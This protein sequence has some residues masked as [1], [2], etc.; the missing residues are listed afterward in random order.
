M[1]RFRAPAVAVAILLSSLLMAAC[2]TTGPAGTPPPGGPPT[3]GP[4]GGGP[5][6][7]GPTGLIS[8]ID[9]AAA[10]PGER[11][12]VTG[13]GFGTTGAATV[14]D[15]AAEIVSWSA[16]TI[17][18]VVP[19][20]Q[21][22]WQ[23]LAVAPEG[24]GSGTAALFVGAETTPEAA[25]DA[26][27]FQEFLDALAPGT[28]VLL[29]AGE[30]GLAGHELIIDGVHLHGHPDGTSIELGSGGMVVIVSQGGA[31]GVSDLDVDGA[32]FELRS[33]D[34]G[35][36]VTLQA[37]PTD[38]TLE[39]LEF[40]G[41]QFGIPPAATPIRH[42]N[43]KVLESHVVASSHVWLQVFSSLEIDGTELLGNE[44]YLLSHVGSTTISGSTIISQGFTSIAADS[45]VRISDSNVRATDGNLSVTAYGSFA[46]T[47]PVPG[48][49]LIERSVLEA[50]EVAANGTPDS[51]SGELSIGAFGG[52]VELLGNPRIEAVDEVHI[53]A[54]AYGGNAATVRLVDNQL[55]G[56]GLDSEGTPLDLPW[57]M[58]AEVHV[59]LN[60]GENSV[61]N[62]LEVTGNDLRSGQRLRVLAGTHNAN[63]TVTGNRMVAG[64]GGLL[65]QMEIS[66]VTGGRL[67]VT[68]NDLEA[69][70]I[71]R[72]R[73]LDE[74]GA[75]GEAVF[76]RNNVKVL[77]GYD[78]I[79]ALS[80]N[81]VSCAYTDNVLYVGERSEME[82]SIY[83][84]CLRPDEPSSTGYEVSRNSVEI[85]GS[86]GSV[87][88]YADAGVSISGNEFDAVELSVENGTGTLQVVD[89]VFSRAMIAL[90]GLEDSVVFDDN[91]V[92]SLANSGTALLIRGGPDVT[93]AG[94]TFERVGTFTGPMTGV[95]FISTLP[96]STV[97]LAGNTFRAYT[98]A[99]RFAYESTDATALVTGNNFDF[100]LDATAAVA[101]V[102]LV[103]SN[104]TLD[105]DTNR[106]GN[107][108]TISQLDDGI[109]LSTYGTSSLEVIFG[110]ILSN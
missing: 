88:V 37:A 56:A 83:L 104:L 30:L 85:A 103:D 36:I 19:E 67:L 52:K 62:V 75:S 2:Q 32:Y 6:I 27:R 93:V 108:T 96:G 51:E 76:S 87:S 101:Q 69:A 44:V 28:H 65:G 77:G 31:A 57:N 40:S 106:W 58:P 89:N 18:L 17:E 70:D 110:T 25:A 81:S 86:S 100:V 7:D 34:P 29:P 42:A 54:T 92:E 66:G 78:S 22:G 94:N 21:G 82:P 53:S 11:V 35:G 64:N 109:R 60:G 12:T 91:E 38:V 84:D 10:L 14:G 26:Q 102:S 63:A 71:V 4:P 61:M 45:S 68:D 16:D 47:P 1:S 8:A 24:G 49:V 33:A 73:S 41:A 13:E 72:V 15:A 95:G 98:H 43:L 46:S 50:N 79:L 20:A 105:L 97:T 48:E 80:L 39:R 9:P 107:L 5:P 90:N 3:D 55:I 23:T 74:Q 99:L 59:S